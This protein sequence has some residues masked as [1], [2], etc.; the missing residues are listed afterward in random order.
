M[1]RIYYSA[2][3]ERFKKEMNRLEKCGSAV[4][5][6]G[7]IGCYF[8]DLSVADEIVKCLNL[9]HEDDGIIYEVRELSNIREQDVD[10]HLIIRS[11]EA[12]DKFCNR[13]IRKNN[14]LEF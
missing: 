3:K 2:N 12:Y 7:T 13:K 10:K 5:P 11:V 14:G 1:Y 4:V 6:M 9:A 8:V